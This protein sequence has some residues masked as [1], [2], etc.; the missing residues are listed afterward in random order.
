MRATQSSNQ[1]TPVKGCSEIDSQRR[2]NSGQISVGPADLSDGQTFS[3]DI[4]PL[5]EEL[6][7]ELNNILMFD[8]IKIDCARVRGDTFILT[9]ISGPPTAPWDHVLEELLQV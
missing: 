4:E 1:L 7:A 2:Q 8:L 5:N 6:V 3:S 9:A